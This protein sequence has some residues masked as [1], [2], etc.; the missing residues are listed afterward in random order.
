M[1]I[2]LRKN[3]INNPIMLPQYALHRQP[4]PL[5]DEERQTATLFVND[6]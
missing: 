6:R 4:R 2:W 1:H 5:S 3:D